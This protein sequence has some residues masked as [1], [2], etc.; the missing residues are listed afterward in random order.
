MG[1][2]PFTA[3]PRCMIWI[4]A[5]LD[6][7]RLLDMLSK[8]KAAVTL[9]LLGTFAPLCT[10]DCWIPGA[11]YGDLCEEAA[12]NGGSRR[13]LLWHGG[14]A[15]FLDDPD[16]DLSMGAEYRGDGGTLHDSDITGSP[17][18]GERECILAM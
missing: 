15:S 8:R 12:A 14:G 9:I 17:T 5:N 6:E 4:D 1:N 11:V 18:L 10:S 13:R 3:T 16:H 7:H 2:N